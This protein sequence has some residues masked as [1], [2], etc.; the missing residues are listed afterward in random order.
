MQPPL[1]I[2]GNLTNRVGFIW[3]ADEIIEDDLLAP[4]QKAGELRFLNVGRQSQE[5]DYE[6]CKTRWVCESPQ[7]REVDMEHEKIPEYEVVFLHPYIT[8]KDLD[9]R[10]REKHPAPSEWHRAMRRF[11]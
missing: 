3:V 4:I 8:P 11:K 7:F 2:Q 10:L 1:K 6:Y 5:R 9:I